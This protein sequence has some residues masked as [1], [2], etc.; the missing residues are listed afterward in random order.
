MEIKDLSI[1]LWESGN[2]GSRIDVARYIEG[3]FG[4]MGYSSFDSLRRVVSGHISNNEADKEIIEESVRL[5]KQRQRLQDT[6]RIERKSFREYARVENSVGAYAEAI[7]EQLKKYGKGLTRLNVS[8][9]SVKGGG[10]GVIQIT[11]THFNELI[12]VGHNKYDFIIASK[13]LKK[14]INESLRY[15]KFRGVE[16]VLIAF[17]GDLLNSDR[18]ADELL[19]QATNRS[20]ASVLSS[21]LLIQA[22]VEVSQY[23]DVR[24]LSVMGNESRVNKE[25]GFSNEVVSDN[26]DFTIVAMCK[27]MIEASSIDNVTFLSIDT[28]EAVA[29]LDGQR[30]LFMHD[31]GKATSKQKDTQSAIARKF[32]SGDKVDFIVGGHIHAFRGTDISCRSGSMAGSNEYNE[33]GLNLY[34]RASGVCYVAQGKERFY[35]YIDLQDYDNEGYNI[36]DELKAYNAKSV[37]KIKNRT[38]IMEIVI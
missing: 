23:Y 27:Q 8:P 13:R 26:F 14:Y 24:I 29:N 19:N 33:H 37:N 7:L 6:N 10:V 22:I 15:F 36:I 2:F 1:Q 30:W 38:K 16:R 4:L 34:G 5:A 32:L 17:T 3:E 25:M 18:R 20:K 31:V 28:M 9:L 11:D 21:Y 35:Q 12:D